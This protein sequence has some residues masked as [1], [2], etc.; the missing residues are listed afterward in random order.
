MVMVHASV[1][2]A[3]FRLQGDDAFKNKKYDS[4]IEAYT[5]AVEVCA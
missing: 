3:N 5:N 2:A 4:S 1:Q